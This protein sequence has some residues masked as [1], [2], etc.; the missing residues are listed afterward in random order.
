M[1][2][3]V[4]DV[5]REVVTEVAPQELPVAEALEAF[6]DDTIVRR[7]SHPGRRREPLGFGLGELVVTVTPV[8]WIVLDELIRKIT[9]QVGKRLSGRWR[10]K[11]PPRTI[12]PLSR[13]QLELVRRRVLELAP[14]RGVEARQA[15][16]LAD[17]LV[18]HLVL[19]AGEADGDTPAIDD[20][21]G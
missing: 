19:T 15:E 2:V 18:A 10:R 1:A 21:A 13:A 14:A 16:A 12:P 3:R 20:A 8:L 4:R 6:D 9:G 11:R 17:S 7:L 5:V